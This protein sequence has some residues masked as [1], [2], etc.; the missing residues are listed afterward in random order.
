MPTL[1]ELTAEI[2]NAHISN[3]KMNSDEML[4]ELQKVHASLKFIDSGLVIEP[5]RPKLLS[6]KQA[7]KKDEIICLICGKG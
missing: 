7:F 3:K 6:I 4:Q 1:L 2:V 5:K